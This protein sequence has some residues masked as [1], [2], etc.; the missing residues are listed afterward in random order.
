MVEAGKNFHSSYCSLHFILPSNICF[1]CPGSHNSFFSNFNLIFLVPSPGELYVAESDTQRINRIRII[2]SDGRISTFAGADSRC[3]CRDPSCYCHAYDNVSA[4]SAVFSSI[5]SIAV[6]PD[7]VLHIGDQE[8]YR[9]RSVRTVLPEL[10]EQKQYQIFSPNSHEVYIFNRFGQHSE[11]H[12]LV[13]GQTIYKFFYTTHSSDGRLLSVADGTG[14]SFQIIRNSFLE[15]T[16]IDN[17][18]K[19]RVQIFLTAQMKL[20]KRLVAP[21]GYNITFRYHDTTHLMRSKIE[22]GGRSYNY[23]YDEQGRLT[24]A[25]LPTGQVLQLTF[26]LSSHGAEVVV[27]RDGTN[28]V[29]TR[30]RGNTLTHTSG[31]CVMMPLLLTTCVF[32]YTTV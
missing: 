8:G 5:S 22:A 2:T 15:V 11:T 12:N 9:V 26:D 32:V 29:R 31:Q 21:N 24:R 28:P 13:T 7:G 19:Q 14:N 25:V 10:N 3:N 6:T 4:T 17:L 1:C 20:L 16:A 27:T 30:V 23:D 18:Q